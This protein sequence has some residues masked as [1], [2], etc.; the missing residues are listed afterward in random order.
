MLLVE[1]LLIFQLSLL[2][3]Q[4]FLVVGNQVQNFSNFLSD[5]QD[6]LI[7]SGDGLGHIL[8]LLEQ[9]MPLIVFL[10][11]L[12][13]CLIKLNLRCLGRGDFLLQ[14][15]LFPSDL[16]SQLLNLK[17]EF[18]DLGIILLPVLLKSDVVFLFLFAGDR[19]LF[20]LL[21]I[22]VEFQLDL[23]HLLIGLEYPDL[24]IVQSFLMLHYN[25]IVFL[26]LLL[27][28]ATLSFGDLPDV[29]LRFCFLVLRV[30]E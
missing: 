7:P 21:L 1:L 29:I 24:D 3:V 10:L 28:P 26:D 30:Y 27:Q 17:I 22:P 25:L 14:F 19:P 12:F 5:P 23:L 20:Q 2:L 15:L 9:L 8:P 18:P 16:D 11:E 4:Q 6:V 13:S